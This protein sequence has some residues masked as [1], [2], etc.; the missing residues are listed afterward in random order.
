MFTNGDKTRKTPWI[1]QALRGWLIGGFNSNL[2]H[3]K[4]HNGE[5][6]AVGMLQFENIFD[7]SSSVSQIFC[8]ENLSDAKIR[9]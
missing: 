9:S 8:N 7:Y 2:I 6:T 3:T 1:W 4:F 5:S